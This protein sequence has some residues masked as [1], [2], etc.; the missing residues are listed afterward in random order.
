MGSG[1][2]RFPESGL[3]PKFPPS[4]RDGYSGGERSLG[5]NVNGARQLFEFLPR[6]KMTRRLQ[7][8]T[9]KQA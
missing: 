3:L 4:R 5:E 8:P 1:V 7:L 6:P 2:V 9:G